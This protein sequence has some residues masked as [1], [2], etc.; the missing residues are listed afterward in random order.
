MRPEALMVT[1]GG[2]ECL[3]LVCSA[4]LDPGDAIAVEGPTY[5]GALMAFRG[6]EADV[7]EIPM[8]EDGLVVDAFAERLED[9]LRPKLLYVIPEYQNPTGRTLPLERRE[10]L[11]ELCRRHGVL[12]LE[13]VAYRELA[14]GAEPLPT[15]WSLAPDAVVQAGTFSKVFFPGVRLGWASGPAEVVAQLAAAK[16]NTDQC[17]SA[18]GQRMVEEYGRGGH[19]ETQLP[20][21][22]ELYGSHWRALDGALRASMPDGVVV[23]RSRPAASSPGSSCR[24]A[25]TRWSC[26]R[27]RSRPAS[28]SSP[29]RPS[30]RATRGAS[31][32]RLSFSA[33]GEAD[34]A[35]AG[36]R[37]APSSTR[38]SR[39]VN[40]GWVG[41]ALR[42]PTE[43]FG[44]RRP[45]RGR[46]A[47][48]CAPC[49]C[50]PSSSAARS[51]S[52]AS[53]AAT[54]SRCSAMKRLDPGR[55]A[56]DGGRG[57]PLVAVAQAVVLARQEL[58]AGGLDER[59]VEAAVGPGEAGAV[60]ERLLLVGDVPAQRG[61]ERGA[62][63]RGAAGGV[64]LDQHPRLEHVLGLRGRDRHDE[65]AAARIELE[66]ALGL[67]L[68]E[69]LADGRPRRRPGAGRSR[70]R[71]AACRPRSGR[72]AGA[73]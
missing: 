52:P 12:I 45:Q 42:S 69:R 24:R 10:A 29:A 38:C 31:T 1:S 73:P 35:E 36:R 39:E 16:A 25:S 26:A 3:A 57:D 55:V 67:E 20:R 64:L 56:G 4:L 13:D 27:R 66:Q 71:S 68:H 17:A 46:R 15:L 63:A 28:P 41:G 65:R 44:W 51:P 37:L 21:A 22:C 59:V 11:V 48:S 72:R 8:D 30:T 47:S 43:P 14:W 6:A 62:G 61:G 53:S 5:L 2:M 9:G 58:V 19:F 49:R 60:L 34:L 32:L 40:C 70:S 18:L 7:H 50:V 23:D 54:I 33:L